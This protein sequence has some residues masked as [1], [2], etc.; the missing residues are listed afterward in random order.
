ML[1][2]YYSQN[3]KMLEKRPVYRFIDFRC[4]RFPGIISALTIPSGGTSDYIPEMIHAAAQG[5]GYKSFVRPDTQIPFMVMPDAIKALILLSNAPKE[6][7]KNSV[8]NVN[9]FSV[10]A[11][12]I[13]RIVNG[14]F[15]DSLITY[16]PDENRQKIVDSWPMDIDDSRARED[17]GWCPDYDIK[18]AFE[19]YLVPQIKNLY[20]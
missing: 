8:Y 6:T 17:W 5:K 18:K 14:V 10:K 1:G 7:L 2:N 9:S 16:K 12:E 3:Y 20:K 4:L 11:E 15:P 13:A 19:N